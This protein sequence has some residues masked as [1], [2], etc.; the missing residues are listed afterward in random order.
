MLCICILI[1][2]NPFN[3]PSSLEI[4]LNL[5]PLIEYA[6]LLLASSVDV[7]GAATAT[8]AFYTAILLSPTGIQR[9]YINSKLV[10]FHANGVIT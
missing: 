3:V 7:D 9:A 2:K 1:Q 10:I 4:H 6:A 8:A 5:I